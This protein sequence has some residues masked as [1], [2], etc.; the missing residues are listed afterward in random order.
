LTD[1][2]IPD[3]N[4]DIKIGSQYNTSGGD[5]NMDGYVTVGDA[6]TTISYILEENPKPFD[7]KVADVNADGL[8]NISD[9]AAIIDIILDNQAKDQANVAAKAPSRAQGIDTDY[10]YAQ[11]VTIAPSSE[12]EL[13]IGLHNPTHDYCAF[14]CDIMFPQGMTAVS[15]DG[16]VIVDLS[17]RK[18]R[19][20]TIVAKYVSSGALRVVAYSN[21]NAAFADNDGELF[22]VLVETDATFSTDP[23]LITISDIIF[24][25]SSYDEEAGNSVLTDFNFNNTL[26]N[27]NSPEFSGLAYVQN[28][29]LTITLNGRQMTIISPQATQLQIASLDGK[30][31]TINVNQGVTTYDIP[32][33]GF[34]IIN[35][36]KMIVK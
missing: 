16:E 7:A 4:V 26:I 9:V 35:G 11:P 14:Q 18:K 34:Y 20:H 19:S 3:F 30:T 32:C 2:D 29:D 22:S 1:L 27:V 36:Q 12:F 33:A 23:A 25:N 5:V 21:Q 28:E 6:A 17:S 13:G 8:I 15:E 31:R 10:L 24:V